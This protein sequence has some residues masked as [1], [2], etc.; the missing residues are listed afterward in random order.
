MNCNQVQDLAAALIDHEQL[1]PVELVEVEDHLSSCPTCQYEYEM[2]RLTSRIVRT[3]VPIVQ[4][5]FDT[6]R[7]I[8]TAIEEE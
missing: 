2:D 5:P 3:R 6:Y 4:T 7:S 1:G 8:I